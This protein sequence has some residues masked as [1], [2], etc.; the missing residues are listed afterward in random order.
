ML[1][2]T[3]DVMIREDS[4][5][6]GAGGSVE[7]ADHHACREMLRG[8]SRSF[9]AASYLLPGRIAEPAA[10][11]YA[12][13][14]V[15][16]DAVDLG[17]GERGLA[18]MQERLA[19]VYQGRPVNHAAD[20]AFADVV[21]RM[22]IPL[23]LPAALLD[24]FEWDVAGRRYQSLSDLLGYGARV[25]GTVGAMMTLVMGRRD[26]GVLARACD[27]GVAMQ[28]TNIAR[29]VGE[30]AANGRLYLPREWMAE[31]G[32]DPDEWLSSPSHSDALASV[33]ERLLTTAGHLYRR[34]AC[35]IRELPLPCRPGI[36]AARLLYAE[37]G[38]QLAREGLDSVS[39]RTVVPF[40]RKLR[41]CMDALIATLCRGPTR[42]TS[43]PLAE[44]RFLIESVHPSG[45]ESVAPMPH[46]S[47][48]AATTEASLA[49]A[50]ESDV[51]GLR[52]VIGLFE[53]LE[54]RD[55][56]QAMRGATVVDEA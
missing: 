22:Q 32:I 31:A 26:A 20:R 34:A 30:D 21:E 51:T 5:D 25:A 9:F 40:S 55:R 54:R 53:R 1:A 46:T 12:F 8:G 45:D 42:L 41:L 36:H 28:L 27:L 37:I 23:E 24:G 38:N 43:P 39:V 17:D 7:T 11:L 35:G 29:D 49:A 18:Q 50:L 19:R 2:T 52:W 48:D 10:A 16:D 15:A 47:A 44:T 6:S 13:C 56:M 4:V 33:V 3:S 14:R